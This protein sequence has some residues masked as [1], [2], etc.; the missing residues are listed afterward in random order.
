MKKPGPILSVS[1]KT[2]LTAILTGLA[3]FLLWP[4]GLLQDAAGEGLPEQDRDSSGPGGPVAV[5]LLYPAPG[6]LTRTLRFPGYLEPDASVT[7]RPQ[8]SGVIQSLPV[9]LG[10][11]LEEGALLAKIDPSALTLNYRIAETGFEL[12]QSSLTKLRRIYEANGLSL[13]EYEEAVSQYEISRNQRDLALLQLGF[14]EVTAPLSGTVLKIHSSQGSLASPE[15]PLLTMA[16]LS[17][18]K[19]EAAVPEEYYEKFHEEASEWQVRIIR[20]SAPPII[21]EARLYRISPL[22]DPESRS[23]QVVCRVDNRDQ[24]LKPG[25]AVKAEFIVHQERGLTLPVSA[26]RRGNRLFYLDKDSPEV[27]SLTLTSPLFDGE[28]LEVPEYL[29]DRPFIVFGPDN[30]EPGDTVFPVPPIVDAP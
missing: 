28:L 7:V 21:R 19:M 1:L 15:A 8:A 13:K 24:R 14:T 12:A 2:T 5:E 25:M 9:T 3:L 26:L 30:L 23:F 27:K 22:I 4:Q 6:D 18:L 16:D 11:S 20:D 10:D 29:A 17:Y